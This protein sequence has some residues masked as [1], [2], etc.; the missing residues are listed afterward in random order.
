MNTIGK[1]FILLAIC[2]C[3]AIVISIAGIIDGILGVRQMKRDQVSDSCNG[4]TMEE[5][6]MVI[7]MVLDGT[8]SNRYFMVKVILSDGDMD[9]WY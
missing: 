9:S 6:W 5:F 4:I 7:F 8:D 2:C 1:L 3:F